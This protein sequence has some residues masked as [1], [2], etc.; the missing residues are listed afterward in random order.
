MIMEIF[1]DAS[2]YSAKLAKPFLLATAAAC[3]IRFVWI[4]ALVE[5]RYVL[6][7]G[8]EAPNMLLTRGHRVSVST[9]RHGMT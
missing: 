1:I 7:G 2:S 8:H 4:R 6:G 3:A 5:L 9:E